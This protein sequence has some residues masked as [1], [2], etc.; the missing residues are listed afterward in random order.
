MRGSPN[1]CRIEPERQESI[2]QYELGFVGA[3]NMAEAIMRAAISSDLVAAGGIIVADPSPER[4]QVAEAL[5]TVTTEYNADV[6]AQAKQIVLAVKPQMFATVVPELRGL[7]IDE[8]ILISIMAGLSTQRIA[9][10]VG[11]QARIIRVMPNT[12]F[13]VGAGMAG[14]A[15]GEHAREGDEKLALDLFR[16]AGQAVVVS[17]ELIDVVT[18]VSG[19]GPAYLFYLAEA[20]VAA[21]EE[22]GL[23]DQADLL[24]RQTILGA[25][26]LLAASPDSAAEL[27]RKVTS[28]GGTTEAAIHHMDTNNVRDHIF[29]AVHRAADRSR[30]LGR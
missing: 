5:G 10:E 1:T 20:M 8:Q 18:A 11:G 25:A 14:V 24:V 28:P 22:M 7:N 15:L 17:E 13:M 12:P 26:Q 3:G 6:I 16:A 4:R 29:G 23:D 9:S 19:S 21:G 27:R 30:E 2:M